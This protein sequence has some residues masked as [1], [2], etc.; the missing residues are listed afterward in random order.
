MMEPVSADDPTPRAFLRVGGAMVARHQLSLVLAAGC[1]RVICIARAIGPELVELQHD[2]EKAGAS[3]HVVPGSRG[4]SGLVT[5]ADEV[6]VLAEGL[7]PT[8]GD[9]VRLLG[10]PPAVFVQPAEAGIPAGFERID[11]NQASAGM[12]LVPGRLVDRLMELTPDA[13]PG[14]A[15][16]RIALQ[17]GVAQRAV[18]DEV[19]LGGRWLL[20]RSEGEAQ[21]AEDGWMARHTAGGPATPGPV[22]ARMLVRHFGPA[23]LHGGSASLVGVTTG[24]LFAAMALAAAW[25]GFFAIALVFAGVGWV[26]R[27][28][29]G[30]LE[31]LQSEALAGGNDNSWRDAAYELAFDVLI[32]AILVMASPS[33]PGELLFERWF[34]PIMLI[35]LLRLLPRGFPSEWSAWA[36][37]RLVLV[38]LL[39]GMVVGRVID[40]G[41]P[42][43]AALLLL[44]GLVLPR[45]DEP[46]K[47]ASPVG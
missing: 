15:L 3:F 27:R 4:L 24:V 10:G 45:D 43:L 16:L 36:T 13:D 7:L 41:V 38:F 12:M 2:A 5:A 33:L 22:V 8:A 35:G 42:A 20:V 28:A 17:A 44:A 37:D 32:G 9:A 34:A 6:L 23:L 18:P 40:P 29:S 39:S 31:A 1:G 19:R 30:L 21:A 46:G 11:L 14:S 47:R 25:F 26:I